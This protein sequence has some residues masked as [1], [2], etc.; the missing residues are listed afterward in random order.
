MMQD[1]KRYIERKMKKIDYIHTKL[2]EGYDDVE[3]RYR[4]V[5]DEISVL[6]GVTKGLSNY[7][8]GGTILKNLSSWST[9]LGKSTN[10][11]SLRRDDIYTDTAFVGMELANSVSDKHLKQVCSDFSASYEGIAADKRKMNEKM[12]DIVE[13][14]AVLK[15]KCRHIDHQRTTVKN[16]RYDLEELVQS[17]VY[18]EEEKEALEKKFTKNAKEVVVDMTEF[19]H[20]SMINGII[21]KIAQAHREFCEKA[22]DHL[23]KFN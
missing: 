9:T 10:I 14:L 17:N 19:M 20:L 4:K 22:A 15:K 6:Q 3:T 13:E 11:K 21:M 16:T 23:A 2:P 1:A 8:F 18:K 12:S 7:E 5:R